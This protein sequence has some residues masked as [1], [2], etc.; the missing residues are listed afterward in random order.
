MVVQLVAGRLHAVWLFLQIVAV[1]PLDGAREKLRQDCCDQI[2]SQHW[3]LTVTH[4]GPPPLFF[5]SLTIIVKYPVFFF[6]P[7][8]R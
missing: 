8:A 7:G 4:L 1:E 5:P 3:P 2:T 6:S